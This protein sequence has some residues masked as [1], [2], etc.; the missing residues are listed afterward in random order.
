MNDIFV[1]AEDGRGERNLSHSADEDWGPTWAPDGSRVAWVSA[2]TSRLLILGM[3]GSRPTGEAAAGPIVRDAYVWSP[4]GTRIAFS[5]YEDPGSRGISGGQIL[6]ASIAS[7]RVD[8]L[9]ASPT[10]VLEIDHLVEGLSWQP[11]EVET[12]EVSAVAGA[13]P[14]AD[15]VGRGLADD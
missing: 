5:S 15:P 13:L 14:S 9:Q 11:L 3:D 1:V 7:I 8:D 10:P 6:E 4:D 12:R 2:S